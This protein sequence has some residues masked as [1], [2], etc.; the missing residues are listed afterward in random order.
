MIALYA[1]DIIIFFL[2][3]ICLLMLTL[4]LHG[5]AIMPSAAAAIR[6]LRIDVDAIAFTRYYFILRRQRHVADAWLLIR[7]WYFHYFLRALMF[8]DAAESADITL[9]SDY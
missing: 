4:L 5:Y 9:F 1:F 2:A 6:Y 7:Y 3:D 8:Q